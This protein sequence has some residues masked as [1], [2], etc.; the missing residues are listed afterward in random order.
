MNADPKTSRVVDRSDGG[1]IGG[2]Y[3][4][5]SSNTLPTNTTPKSSSTTAF[6]LDAVSA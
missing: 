1:G 4:E 5:G 6:I 2:M 3:L